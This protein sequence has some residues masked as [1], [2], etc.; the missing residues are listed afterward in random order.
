MPQMHHNSTF[1]QHF[2]ELKTTATDRTDTT[3]EDLDTGADHLAGT[4]AHQLQ[5]ADIL[6][7][8]LD[9][10]HTASTDIGKALHHLTLAL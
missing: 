5:E 1:L 9:T 10:T 8:Q 2:A 3:T 7:S 6:I 4:A